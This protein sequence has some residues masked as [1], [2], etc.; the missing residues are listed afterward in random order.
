VNGPVH[1]QIIGRELP[2]GGGPVAKVRRSVPH[3][4]G[5]V[6]LQYAA[7]ANHRAWT[8][9]PN[10]RGVDSCRTQPIARPDVVS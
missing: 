2:F 4:G 1:G 6:K 8:R 7:G 10:Q 5:R 9:A 3:G